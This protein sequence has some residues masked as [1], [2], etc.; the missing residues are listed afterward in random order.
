[1]NETNII[2]ANRQRVGIDTDKELARRIGMPESTFKYRI[3][4]PTSWIRYELQAIIE[5]TKMPDA[6]I[7]TLMKGV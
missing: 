5:I 4:H 6:D 2:R 1:M 7:V 3:K